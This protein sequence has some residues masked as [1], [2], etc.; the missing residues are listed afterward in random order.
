[1]VQGSVAICLRGAWP[2]NLR[3]R[4]V[5]KSSCQGPQPLLKLSMLKRSRGKSSAARLLATFRRGP[6]NLFFSIFYAGSAA[7]DLRIGMVETEWDVGS[8]ADALMSGGIPNG[9]GDEPA[10]QF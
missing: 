7:E 2:Q 5:P 10:V 4:L 1:M 6:K 8:E 9:S 3:G